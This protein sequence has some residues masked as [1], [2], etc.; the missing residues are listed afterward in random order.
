MSGL[1]D[2]LNLRPG[3]RRLVVISALVLFVVLNFVFV[4]PL[5]GSWNTANLRMLKAQEKLT[6]WQTEVKQRA[7]YER[8]LKEFEEDNPTVPPEDQ[9][10]Q[11]LRVIQNQAALSGVNLVQVSRAQTKTNE[12]F[13]EQLQTIQI[14]ADQEQLVNFLYALGS[15]ESLIRVR[16]I[17][18]RPDAPRFSL[19]GSVKLVASYAKKPGTRGSSPPAAKPPETA[20]GPMASGDAPA[21]AA[22][23]PRGPATAFPARTNAP[24][25]TVAANAS[26]PAAKLSTWEKVKG[27]FGSAPATNAPKPAASAVKPAAAPKPTNA[28]AA[29]PAPPGTPPARN[30]AVPPAPP[31][32]P[33]TPGPTP[34]K[35]VEKEEK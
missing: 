4:F 10:L 34:A 18:L 24:A 12:F 28:P 26:A 11:F 17:S 14:Q 8:R 1:L 31:G 32:R 29:R 5:F 15:G 3:E 33:G 16:E 7:E 25:T 35:P 23:A 27:W 6:R 30:A 13:L 9:L 21:S 19:G 2:R 22:A 20:A